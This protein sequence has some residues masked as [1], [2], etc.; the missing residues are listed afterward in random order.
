MFRRVAE[1]CVK[2]ILSV[3]S[4]VTL[5]QT[6]CRKTAS[7]NVAVEDRVVNIAHHCSGVSGFGSRPW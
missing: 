7:Q 5:L 6:F 1:L 4:S 3:I 2:D